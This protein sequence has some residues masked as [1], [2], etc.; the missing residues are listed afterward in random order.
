MVVGD[1]L[2]FDVACSLNE[3]L[4]ENGRVSKGLERLA[5]ALE[6]LLEAG[7]AK[8]PGESRDR[9]PRPWP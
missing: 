3:L 1:D 8:A 7:W 5:R 2:H 4:D 6:K 9:R